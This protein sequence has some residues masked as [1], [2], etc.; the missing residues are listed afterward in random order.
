MLLKVSPNRSGVV[1]HLDVSSVRLRQSSCSCCKEDSV[2]LQ[3]SMM[4]MPRTH[5]AEP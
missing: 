4:S 3:A 2:E 5:D 1:T